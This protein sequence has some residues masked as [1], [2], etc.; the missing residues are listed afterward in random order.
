MAAT[1]TATPTRDDLE[2]RARKAIA[3]AARLPDRG[4]DT[5]RI[6]AAAVAEVDR[7]L[8]AYLDAR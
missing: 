7:A 2:A 3:R 6:K 1:A 4:H 8:D 5:G